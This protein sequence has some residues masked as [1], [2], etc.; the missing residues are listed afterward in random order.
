MLPKALGNV[1]LGQEI[2]TVGRIDP[3]FSGGS[4]TLAGTLHGKPFART[5]PIARP[6]ATLS[7][8]PLVP[9]LYAEARIGELLQM[10]DETSAAASIALSTRFHVMSRLTSLLVLENERMFAEFGVART[11]R[12]AEEQSDHAFGEPGRVAGETAS[13]GMLGALTGAPQGDEK[14]ATGNLWGDALE[15]SFGAGGLGLSGVGEGGGGRGDGIGLGKIGTIG[16][17]ASVSGGNTTGQGFGGGSGRLGGSHQAGAPR[18]RMGAT[19]VSGRLPPEIIQRVVRQN[20]GRMRFCY[21][22][23]LV[24]KPELAGRVA[25]RFLIGSDGR[26]QSSSG[27]WRALS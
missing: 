1:A 12:R 21:E 17:G 9:R 6:S 10:G 5:L 19:Q 14:S 26:V 22:Q 2:V 7:Q 13:F 27:V 18:V 20:F 3:R 11:A 23:G 25:V 15:D 4:V 24:R 16:H 8:N